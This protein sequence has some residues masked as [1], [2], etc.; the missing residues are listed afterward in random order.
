[1]GREAGESGLRNVGGHPH[2]WAPFTQPQAAQGGLAERGQG[3]SLGRPHCTARLQRSLETIES[4]LPTLSVQTGKPRLWVGKT[5]AQ[6]DTA[7]LV[8][9]GDKETWNDGGRERQAQRLTG[10][11]TQ[12]R[13]QQ[14]TEAGTQ[15]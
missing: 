3:L 7:E 5:F 14:E 15:H 8:V 2:A 13:R 10:E 12:C 9:E 11:N 4:R 6:G 1:M